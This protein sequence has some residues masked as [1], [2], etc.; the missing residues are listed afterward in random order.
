MT[1]LRSLSFRLALAYMALFT[2]SLAVLVAATWWMTIHQPLKAAQTVVDREAAELATIYIADGGAVLSAELARR[3][4]ALS[5]RKP[6][7]AFIDSRG[8]TATANL[9]TWPAAQRNGLIRLEADIYRDGDEE[10]HEALVRDRVFDDGARL[11]VGRDI[12]DIDGREELLAGTVGWI[13]GLSLILSMLGGFLMSRVIG[14]RLES[15]AST[16]RRV[17]DGDLSG[18]VPVRGSGDDFDRLSVTLN[19]MLDRIQNL[20]GSVQRVSDNVA[21]ELRTPLTRLQADL[22]ELEQAGDAERSELI[23][24][25]Q[26]DAQRLQAMFDALLRIARIDSGR[27]ALDARPVPLAPL[28]RDLAELYSPAAE[29]GGLA[30]ATD[31]APNVTVNGDPDLIFQAVSNLLDNA[32]KFTGAGGSISLTL[33]EQNGEAVIRVSDTGVGADA[34]AASLSRLTERFYRAPGTEHVEGSGLGLSL[35]AAIVKAHGGRLMF[36]SKGGMTVSWYLPT[37]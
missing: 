35:V 34:D 6:F 26:T 36:E 22:D 23:E 30:I 15:V 14:A 7:H 8:V 2:A 12:E 18:R 16:A 5:D 32:L 28:L 17:I 19:V 33:G 13:V 11:L 20:V 3:A 1:I 27:H 29:A 10:D 37:E 31:L 9:P 4:G 25:V 21:H 24:R